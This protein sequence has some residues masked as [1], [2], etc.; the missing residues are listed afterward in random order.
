MRAGILTGVMCAV[1]SL[2]FTAHSNAETP[3][4]LSIIRVT[5]TGDDVPSTRQIVLE[6]NRPVV[7]VGRMERTAEEV[8]IKTEP[9]INCQWR[10]LNTTSLSCNLDEKDSLKPA[11]RY[12]LSVDP[13][14]KAEDGGKL[15]KSAEYSF[16]TE[17][18]KVSYTSFRTWKAPGSPVIRLVL[19]QPVSKSS[20]EEHIYMMTENPAIRIKLKA[21]PDEEDQILPDYI[22]APTEKVWIKIDPQSRKSD[23]KKTELNGE[24]ARRVWL[25]E[26]EQAL[27]LDQSARLKIEKGILSAEGPEAGSEERDIV[28]FNTFPEFEFVGVRCSSNAEDEVLVKPGEVQ[29]LLCNPMRSV[30]LAFT[31]PVLRS[32]VK[33]MATFAPDLAGGRKDFNPWGDENRDYSYLDFPHTKGRLYYVSLPF[34]L[35]AAQTYN[36]K[37]AAEDKSM[38]AKL[39]SMVGKKQEPLLEDQFGRQL[40]KPVDMNFA[41]N[42]RNP[43]FEMPYHDAVLEHG[44]DSD[45][46]LYVNNL[47]SYKFNYRMVTATGA[48]E[49]KTYKKDVQKINDVQYAVPLGV[50]EMLD[51]KSGAIFGQLQ[52]SPEVASKWEG[53]YRLFAQVTP[54]QAH[55]KFGH[56]SSLIWV[57]DL[58]T[59][60][61]VKDVKVSVYKDAFTTLSLPKDELATATTDEN[62]IATLPG[63]ETLDPHH[64][65]TERGSD[66]DKQI[67]VRMDKGDDMALLP[68]SYNFSLNTW[69]FTDD[70][71]SSSIEDRYGHLKSWGMTAQ[72]IYRTG[73][74]IQYKIFLRNQN[75]RTLTEPPKGNYTLEITDPMGKTVQSIDDVTFSDFGAYA[76]EY[77]IPE[78]GAVGW[79]YFNLKATFPEDEGQD[80][81]QR[82]ISL[83]PLSVLVADFTPS[84]FKVE[85]ELGGKKFHPDDEMNIE[86]RAALHSG[87][88]YGDAAVRTTVT[89]RKGY[90]S[91]D[92]PELRDFTFGVSEEGEQTD[93]LYQK[94]AMLDDKGEWIQKFKLPQQPIYFGKLEV[95]SAVQDDRG[96]S[97]A[98]LAYADYI[99]V[100]RFV[101]LK[102]PEWFYE[103]KKP[104]T[105]Q[106]VVVDENGVEAAGTKMAIKLEREEINVAKVKGAGNAYLSDITREWKEVKNW[107]LKSTKDIADVAYT[108]DKAGSY[109]ATATVEDSKGR[110]H[111]TMLSFW[112]SGDDYVQWN[113]Q[114]N[115]ELPIVPE[116]N[117]YKIGETAKFLIKNPYPDAT[118][119]V[120]VERYGVIDHFMKKLDGSAPVLEIPVKPD[121]MPGFYLSVLVV[122]PRVD[123]QVPELGQIDM[124]KPAFRMG[125]VT[126]PVRDLYKEVK[127]DVK[128]ARDVYRPR[129]KVKVSLEAAPLNPPEKKEPI[130][131]AVAVLDESVFDLIPIGRTAYDPY[132]GFYNLDSLDLR[133]YSLLYR[134][135][136][137]QKF[138]KKGANP[139]GDGGADVDMRT[140]FKYVS[141]WNPAVKTDKDGKAQIEFDAPDNLTGWRVFA[142]A[143][144]PTDRL[145]LGEGEFK[146]NRPTELRPVMPNQVRE[147]DSFT[148]GFS[149]MNRT[150]K[151]RTIKVSITATGDVVEEKVTKEETVTLEPYKRTTVSMPLKTGLLAIDRDT[152]N[153]KIVF[154]AIAEDMEDS[155]GTEYTLPILK[156]RVIDV[157]ATYGTSTE[158][159]I[160]EHIA[161]PA[162]IYTDVGDV[163]VVLSP[164]VMANLTGAFKYMRDY[165]YPCWEQVLTQGVMAAHYK[166]LKPWLPADFKWKD[167]E[168]LP[169]SMLERAA[170][171]QAPNGGMAYF[172]PTDER[173]DPYL[174]AYTALAFQWL[175]KDGYDVPP[176]VE[177]KLN[178]YLKNF[179]RQEAAPDFYQPG[180][181]STVRAVALAALA[182]EGKIDSSDVKRYQPH[183][184]EMSLFGKAHFMDAAMLFE[185]TQDAAKEAADMIFAT[186]NETGG[187]FMFN[188]TLDDGYTRILAT[189]LRDNCAI[190]SSFVAYGKKGGAELIGDK[191]F[192]L[193]RMITQSRGSRD[194]WENTQENMF[195]MAALV[196]Y[197]R[198]YES[199][200][201]SM[202]VKASLDSNEFGKTSFRDFRDE[203]VTLTKP[204][205]ADDPGKT[206]NLTL[207]REG[208]GRVY[209]AA[210]LRYAP[211]TGWQ[212]HVNAGMD[213]GREYSV[214]RDGAWVILKDKMDVKRGENVRVDI[215]LS[216]PSAR[217][218]VVVNDPLPGGL[219]TVNRDLKTASSVDDAAA[220]YDQE[221]GSLWFKYN[222]W[223]EFNA[224]FWSFYHRELRHDSA[225]F[226]ADWLPAGNYHLSYMTQAIADGDFAAPP[227]RAEEMYEPD[228]YG[229]GDDA[230]L[231]I[232]TE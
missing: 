84:P 147:E 188:E 16:L 41:T 130:E 197:A 218:F 69:S 40:P 81:D 199:V 26:P 94:S 158:N 33:D 185:D 92:R 113:D 213:I 72:G 15:E 154:K 196:D 27:P 106:A 88:P 136:G 51:G 12:K 57:T 167:A 90:F 220:V 120:T 198:V 211:K 1:L 53:E 56:F 105:F 19:N 73:D 128:V 89:L 226:Y 54:W 49:Y 42:H 39:K 64:A 146:V 195:C 177:D 76:G 168:A 50:R 169:K 225:R 178:E 148:G 141:Y 209:Y 52:T 179:L 173:A 206:R 227:V 95:E 117:E 46:P 166:E 82:E 70:G 219:E 228:V 58:A 111:E 107:D 116:K 47:D 224:S 187:K 23:D 78:S 77:K 162:D 121:Y 14:I 100:D 103:S 96:K 75:D 28:T 122:S 150:D 86:S 98:S 97:V 22:W 123:A 133:N 38:M 35:K 175:K 118:A 87:G 48:Q 79:Y 174:S 184:K 194:H 180:M 151:P 186:G 32:Q 55:L 125:Y 223:R 135:I 216:I 119:L 61:P 71:T 210:R 182:Q 24:E 153:G 5:P 160:E 68:L 60:Q 17:R 10:W 205:A 171:Y 221:G 203:P 193:V 83:S 9:A 45:L 192:K 189:P 11:T 104:M 8:G 172:L 31:A 208:D 44:I 43:N 36:V 152:P 25:V 102:S 63:A 140:L 207:S 80:I 29:G 13:V 144:S 110:S 85:T 59:G 212:N 115:L 134:L 6:F 99:G 232:K 112:V 131:L 229:R 142:V 124:G 138:D 18:P 202:T 190:L 231:T 200:K 181:K 143:T 4:N 170:N 126:V 101:G 129:E 201:P 3:K 34:G 155:D 21:T 163:S 127:V 139:G 137:K 2:A 108:P 65:F 159:K 149:V 215:Y 176:E 66:S 222:D 114:D 164:S 191:P 156:K 145:G 93:Q 7:P 91:S 217:N 230:S 62:G 165:P 204:I 109:R 161:F 74:T 20:V 183:L 132:E 30:S 214:R 37:L 157:G 67:F